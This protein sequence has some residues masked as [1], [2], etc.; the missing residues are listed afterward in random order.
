M[1]SYVCHGPVDVA[2]Y[3]GNLVE[4]ASIWKCPIALGSID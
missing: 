2:G 3:G 4:S 1:I